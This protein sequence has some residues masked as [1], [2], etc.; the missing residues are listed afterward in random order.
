[1]MK[2]SRAL[3]KL[4]TKIGWPLLAGSLVVELWLLLSLVV[5]PGWVLPTVL[6]LIVHVFA[7]LIAAMVIS[8]LLNPTIQ[9]S[10]AR[11]E[12][13][14]KV[15]LSN[16]GIVP[17]TTLA[18]FLSLGIPFVGTVGAAAALI[19]GAHYSRARHRQEVY[20]QFTDNAELPF[21]SPVGRVSSGIDSRSLTEQIT[22]STDSNTLYKKV[23]ATGRIRTS[24]SVDTL[25]KAV[26]HSDERIRLTAY[27]TLDKKSSQLNLTIQRLEKE[28][29]SHEGQD[30][31]N[32]WLLIASNYWELLTLEKD[33]PVA[34]KQLLSK[35]ANAATTAISI[36]P[37][38]RNAHFTL[39]RISLQQNNPQRAAVA[40]HQAISLGMPE[41]KVLPY[42]A[43]AAFDQREFSKVSALLESI[44]PAF[45]RYPPL[46][47]V[48]RYW[49]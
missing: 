28:V 17:I 45:T 8:F 21:V 26:R 4:L 6:W 9:A 48:A 40:F 31:S 12:F 25:K 35:A 38:N 11:P 23:L 3:L 19:V 37:T 34:R 7:S 43:E 47:H 33:E 2:T 44:D 41:E 18:F 22:F 27:Q 24:L 46:S 29:A 14:S 20:W 1:M 16:E 49:S 36:V 32:T 13:K 5:Y 15:S 42:L 39:G 30:K 10:V